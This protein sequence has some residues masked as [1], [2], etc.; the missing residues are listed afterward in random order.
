MADTI[1]A[2]WKKEGKSGVKFL[3]GQITINEEKISL[4]VFPNT[5]KKESKHPDYN[6]VLN[7]YNNNKQDNKQSNKQYNKHDNKK[8]I[9]D[10]DKKDDFMSSEEDPF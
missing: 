1:G 5:N 2:F 10:F 8:N 6:V 7:D 9:V 4:T 3:S